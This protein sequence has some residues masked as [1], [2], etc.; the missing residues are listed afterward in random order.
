MLDFILQLDTKLFEFIN[1][2]LSNQFFDGL[3]PWFRN[4]YFWVPLYVFLAFLCLS[5]FGRK[6]YVILLT[7]ILVVVFCDQISSSILKPTVKRERPCNSEMLQENI[8]ILAPCRN[9]FSFT[10][11]HATNHFGIATFFALVFGLRV[12][13]IRYLLYAWAG[14]VSLSQ[15][16]VGLHYP[17]DI[18][19]GA[20][21]GILIASLLFILLSKYYLMIPQD[22]T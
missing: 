16:Y 5:E 3:I 18:L 7:A 22:K 6:S 12:G 17:F 21:V 11:S 10:S 8:K 9:S 4:R 20:I 19:C 14:L 2:G 1:Q 13:K 15:V